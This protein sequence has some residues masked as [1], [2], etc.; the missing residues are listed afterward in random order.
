[1]DETWLKVLP[2]A[3]RNTSIYIEHEAAEN[4]RWFIIISSICFRLFA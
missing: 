4:E 2:I 3:L 1:M